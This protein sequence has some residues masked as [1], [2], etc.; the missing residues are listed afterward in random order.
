MGTVQSSTVDHTVLGALNTVA[1]TRCHQGFHIDS[2][3]ERNFISLITREKIEITSR[4]TIPHSESV[5]HNDISHEFQL[6]G[7]RTAQGDVRVN[8][9][10]GAGI[11]GQLTGQLSGELDADFSVEANEIWKED[12]LCSPPGVRMEFQGNHTHISHTVR[13]TVQADYPIRV[14]DRKPVHVGAGVG[15]G[16]G[17]VVGG[18]AGIG[19]GI[20]AGALIGSIVPVAGTII[21]GAIGGV[22]GGI[23]GAVAGAG[24]GSG[25]GA[26][27]GAIRSN[28]EYVTILARDV[29]K[30]LRQFSEDEDNNVVQC[31]V[32]ENTVCP[33]RR[34]NLTPAN[35]RQ[36]SD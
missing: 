11:R 19:G 16:T 4:C 17:G 30:L 24:V 12:P 13:L 31:T 25:A 26:A 29:F 33:S 9:E 1:R 28:V 22:V 2:K 20:A 21:G 14:Y 34:C 18:A 36:Q 23:G 8:F 3:D 5:V 7:Q 32:V 35:G 10:G 27:G 6:P 15:G